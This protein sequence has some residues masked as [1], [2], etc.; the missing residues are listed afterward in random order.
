MNR[1]YTTYGTWR[2]GQPYKSYTSPQS[3]FSRKALP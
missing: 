3:C 1:T 2:T